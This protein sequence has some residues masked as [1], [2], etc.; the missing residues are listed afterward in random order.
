MKHYLIIAALL[1]GFGGTALAQKVTLKTN[2]LY[3]ATTTANLGTEIALGKKITLDISAN[4][5][6]W[7][8]DEG[9]QWKHWM[10]QPELRFW[11]CEKFN[12][13]F[14]GFHGHYAKY[15]VG[16]IP[17]THNMREY[18]YKGDLWG[19]GISYGYSWVLGK[20]W[21]LEATIGAGYARL[22]HEKARMDDPYKTPIKN[23][24]KNYWGPTKLGLTLVFVLN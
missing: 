13:H 9:R 6:G 17:W 7:K 15:T 12:G 2:L 3:D 23:E 1:F 11:M 22:N 16:N 19:A 14:F 18:R 21:N 4:Y 8:W 24:K 20:R 10:V 5:N